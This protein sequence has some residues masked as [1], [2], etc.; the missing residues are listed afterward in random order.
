[1]PVEKLEWKV[2]RVEGERTTFNE[3]LRSYQNK[4]G[5]SLQITH[6]PTSELEK[7]SDAASGI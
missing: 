6:I 1:M 2:F 7:R 5:K 4:A 3:I